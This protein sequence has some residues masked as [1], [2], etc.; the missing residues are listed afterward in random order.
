MIGSLCC[1]AEI[2]RTLNQLYFNK[3][4][5]KKHMSQ[6]LGNGNNASGI[7]LQGILK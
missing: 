7:S 3:N 2:D 4:I 6:K 1:R 5:L